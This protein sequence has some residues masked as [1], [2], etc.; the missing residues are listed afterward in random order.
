[1][2]L[3]NAPLKYSMKFIIPVHVKMPPTKYS[4]ESLKAGN[5]IILRSVQ[6]SMKKVL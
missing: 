2:K 5:Y 3:F 6:L 1:M 4:S